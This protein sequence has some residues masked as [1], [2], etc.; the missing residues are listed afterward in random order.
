MIYWVYEI[1]IDGIRRY[2][3]ITNDLEKR[4]K[5]HNY[6][7]KKDNKKM[8]YKMIKKTNGDNYYI[9]LEKLKPFKEKVDAR[10]FECLIILNDYFGQKKLWQRVPR[11]SD[12]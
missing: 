6:L 2:I 1:K 12:I 8:L 7:I 10:R 4:Q 5:Q 11:I 3:G 9:S